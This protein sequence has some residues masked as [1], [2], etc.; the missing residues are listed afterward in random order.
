VCARGLATPCHPCGVLRYG[1]SVRQ[2]LVYLVI[3]VGLLLG[4]LLPGQTA[5]ATPGGLFVVWF[6]TS[7]LVGSAIDGSGIQL[8]GIYRRHV[9]WTQVSDVTTR[10]F[11][12]C[13]IVVLRLGSRGRRRLRAPFTGPLQRDR[14][15]D[16][17]VETIRHCW[18]HSTG[19][20]AS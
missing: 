1:L 2:R 7:A 9:P 11:L 18:Q 16:A 3:G 19:Q 15:F 13:T 4:A 17:K 5:L 10:R 20:L 6:F 8:R 12:G 14:D